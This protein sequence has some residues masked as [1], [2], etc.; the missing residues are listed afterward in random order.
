MLK[1]NLYYWNST[2]NEQ[3]VNS[4]YDKFSNLNE[5]EKEIATYVLAC[6]TALIS[7]FIGP[8]RKKLTSEKITDKKMKTVTAEEHMGILI[9]CFEMFS[10]ILGL[11]NYQNL[12][13]QTDKKIFGN[14]Y[15]INTV[16]DKLDRKSIQVL[17]MT[18]G[19]VIAEKSKIIDKDDPV[20]TFS[21]FSLVSE[22]IMEITNRVHKIEMKS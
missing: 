15:L 2:H 12:F 9:L 14:N 20:F 4:V 22:N 21:F 10:K 8:D 7:N 13:T 1:G 11:N 3:A 19:K 6:S 5:K 17:I 18:Y 16:E